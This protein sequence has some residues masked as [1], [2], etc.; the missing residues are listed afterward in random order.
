MMLAGFLFS[1]YVAFAGEA[2][3]TLFVLERTTNKNQL[4]YERINNGKVEIHPYWQMLA[5]DGHLE[6]LNSYERNKVYGT[7]VSERDG[8]AQ[9]I[10][11]ALPS[12]PFRVMAGDSFATMNL[13][14]KDR[15]VKR[16]FIHA[17]SGL[18]PA[19]TFIDIECEDAHVRLT[20][21]AGNK[22]SEKLLP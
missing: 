1:Q 10:I 8:S 14:G 15:A 16:V 5:T 20:S 9:F 18:M 4:I 12:Y 13:L 22:W 19:I 7:V 21:E 3:T 2:K 17:S 11:K 6:E